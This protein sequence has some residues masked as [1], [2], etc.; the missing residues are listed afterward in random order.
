L[1]NHLIKE[2]SPYLLQHANNPVDWYPWGEEALKR[3]RSEDKPILLSIGYSAC[4]WCHVMAHQCFENEAIASLMNEKFINIKVDREEHPELDSIYMEAVQLMSKSG[5]WPLTVFLTPD[6]KP[7]YGGTYFP[8]EDMS[9]L[10]GFPRVLSVVSGAYHNHRSDIEETAEKITDTL[11]SAANKSSGNQDLSEGILK[12]AFSA[13]RSQFDNDNGGFGS[14]PKFPN[15]LALEFLLRYYSRFKETAALTMVELTLGKMADGGIHD[16]IGGG[17]HRYATDDAWQVP[18]FEKMLYD[19]ALL[20]RIYLHTYLVTHNL[21]Y[22][23][24]AEDILDYVLREMTSEDGGFYSSQDADSEGEEGKY[25]LW[26]ADEINNVLGMTQG[27]RACRY[28]GVDSTGNFEGRSILHRTGYNEIPDFISE[29]KKTLMEVRGKRVKPARDE[30]TL[31]SWNGLMLA[32][33]AEAALVLNREDFKTAALK[34]GFF[35][36]NSMASGGKIQHTFKDGKAKITGFLEDYTQVIEGLLFLHGLTL[37][38]KWLNA[39]IKLCENMA[40]LY[41]NSSTGLLS[42]TVSARKDLITQPRNEYDGVVPSASSAAA[43]VFQKM[44]LITGNSAYSTIA[45]RELSSVKKAMLDYPVGYCNWLCDL[46]FYLSDPVE[47]AIAGSLKDSETVELLRV[48]GSKWIPNK[49]L[50]GLDPTDP[51]SCKS[52]PL[53]AERSMINGRPTVYLCRN[54]FCRAPITDK[55][56]LE[57]VLE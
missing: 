54:N 37:E 31:A 7:F 30:K 2:T 29:T 18:H 36:L 10:P 9:H 55:E 32:S 23:G 41:I 35:L 20:A 52:S 3:A 49:V 15:T 45:S 56:A 4:H 21:F 6:L 26:T 39:G 24:I 40:A 42:D 5:G 12:G 48:I 19:N 27:Q 1:P 46:E 16:Q 57:K 14:A 38:G 47:I 53:L 44:A 17:F 25:Y 33:L 28:F 13:L 22:A 43:F 51:E 50:V 8:P 11:I 34:N